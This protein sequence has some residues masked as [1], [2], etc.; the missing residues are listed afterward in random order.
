M[1]VRPELRDPTLVLAFEG[2]NDAGEAAS[3]AARYVAEAIAAAP[4]AEID[5]EPF[6]DFTVRRPSVEVGEGGVRRITWP[7]ARFLYGS[8]DMERELV[9]GLAI[10]PHLRWRSY[11]DH[12]AAL[13]AALR[14]P[15]VVLLGAHLADVLYSRPVGISGFSSP[16]ALLDELG[17][18]HSSYEGPTGIIG[19]LAERLAREGVEVLS[20]WAALPH[21]ISAQPN[22]RGSLALVQ[23]LQRAL[24]LKVDPAPLERMAAEFEERI[25]ALVA[26]DPELSEYVRQLKRREFAQ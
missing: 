22:P 6:F 26:A 13:V 16:P 20:L 10:E 4:L 23:V 14:V 1:H 24:A 18:A 25:S 2:W 3:E 8:A 19:V 17:V 12:V 21:Y 15:R 11:V 7:T 9:V 5:P